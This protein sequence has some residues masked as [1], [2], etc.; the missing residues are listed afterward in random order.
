MIKFYWKL[1][2]DGIVKNKSLYLPYIICNIFLVAILYL[3]LAL[4]NLITH[5]N[6]LQSFSV[7]ATLLQLG[8]IIIL[9]FLIV[10]EL[11]ISNFILNK[12]QSD[13]GVINVLGFN[14]KNI[15]KLNGF[16]LI[17]NLLV[18]LFGGLIIGIF[19]SR[20]FIDVLLKLIQLDIKVKFSV[21][22]FVIL[23]V[24]GFFGCLFVG[25]WVLNGFRILKTKT[26]DLIKGNR[27]IE[28][29]IKFN[30]LSGILGV[31]LLII[32]YYLAST[33]KKLD[34]APSV[35]FISVSLVIIA[36]YLIFV[37]GINIFLNLLKRWKKVFYRSANFVSIS[38]LL[39]RI[40]Q[41]A[42]GLAN[43]CILYTMVVI[44]I[45]TTLLIYG[46]PNN[47]NKSIFLHNSNIVIEQFNTAPL[48]EFNVDDYSLSKEIANS[49]L[50]DLSDSKIKSF[51][52]LTYKDISI[53]NLDNFNQMEN[54]DIHLDDNKVLLYGNWASNYKKGATLQ[55][56][57]NTFKVAG[58]I[59][60][61]NINNHLIEKVS[62]KKEK[63]IIT[64]HNLSS[65]K[66]N[67]NFGFSS[68]AYIWL[69][70]KDFKTEQKVMKQLNNKLNSN[71][72]VYSVIEGYNTSV[73]AQ[74]SLVGSL[75]FI[76]L[77]LSMIFIVISVII[78]YYKQ[79]NEGYRDRENIQKMIK[80]GMTTKMIKSIIRRQILILFFLPLAFC[81]LHLI[82]AYPIFNL[83]LST[84][85]LS[86]PIYVKLNMM[87]VFA[88]FA[89][90]YIIIYWLTSKRYYQI[91]YHKI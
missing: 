78:V 87:F 62:K 15:W 35:L 50:T 64:N 60:A 44:T 71:Q 5:N 28:K 77:F 25:V 3:F 32:G 7:V 79:I 24:I 70:D 22:I 40:K 65:L 74:Y 61:Q 34:S 85:F 11:Y 58:K 63:I 45:T 6:S 88:V 2:K 73:K 23:M 1:A 54:Q 46:S 53:I 14:K 83:I 17:I 26:V 81:M 76:G 86:D 41:N 39:F 91:I 38:N 82:M 4:Q 48:S 10:F 29:K 16:E 9:A 33:V 56:G 21:S 49:D 31:V 72:K 8:I 80:I 27:R 12:R 55:I 18:S 43:I 52:M 47:Y 67:D 66:T 89:I 20:L 37:S 75:L 69:K 57:N 68:K 90:V 51:Q 19:L 30:Y 13:Y 36:T 84:L 42:V 59:Q